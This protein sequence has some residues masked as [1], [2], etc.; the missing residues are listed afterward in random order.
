MTKAEK[1]TGTSDTYAGKVEYEYCLSCDGALSKRREYS[2]TQSG[3]IIQERRYE[4]DGLNLL[5]VDQR[6][7]TDGDGVIEAG[8]TAWRHVEVNSHRPGA[9]GAQLGKR[10]YLY[11]NGQSTTPSSTTD[12]AYVYDPVGNVWVILSDMGEEV[13][14]FSQDAFGNEL[15]ISP[16]AGTSWQ[17]AR[18]AGIT[19][20]QTG[21]WIDPFTGLYFFHA[22][23][24]D[25]GVG[26]FVG[27][28]PA[29]EYGGRIY[30]LAYNLPTKNVDPTGKFGGCG[31]GGPNCFPPPPPPP[32]PGP[33]SDVV[34]KIYTNPPHFENDVCR[35]KNHCYACCMIR[36][37]SCAGVG[38]I[39]AW[40][41]QGWKEGGDI[42]CAPGSDVCRDWDACN[43][44]IDRGSQYWFS[45]FRSL[46]SDK[47][48]K[49]ACDNPIWD[50]TDSSQCIPDTSP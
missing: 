36:M 46:N 3:N 2:T 4:Y 21:K 37:C 13:Y 19:E 44:G 10:A 49:N 6:V 26:R 40:L 5:R 42:F 50:T 48:C 38:T 16:F 17:T 24:L 25:A 27:R 34:D 45:A 12:Y 15:S 31:I 14:W 22:R 11:A 20:H 23:W 32:P 9:L 1:F 18:T 30:S 8:E 41:A 47:H 33:C 39:A 43:Y 35:H 28:D 29:R 7:D